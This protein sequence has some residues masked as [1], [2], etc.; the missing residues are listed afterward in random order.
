MRLSSQVINGLS[1]VL[2]KLLKSLNGTTIS[3]TFVLPLVGVFTVIFTLDL[4]NSKSV[5]LLFGSF[6]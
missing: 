5:K 2:Q 1:R 4:N 3:T 6:L